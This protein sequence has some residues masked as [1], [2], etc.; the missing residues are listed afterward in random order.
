MPVK[1]IEQRKKTDILPNKNNGLRKDGW[2]NVLSGVGKKQDKTTHS[3]PGQILLLSDTLLSDMYDAPGL[4]SVVI[5]TLPND[6][7][8]AGWEYEND[9]EQKIENEMT[10]LDATVKINEAIKYTRVYRGAI[11]VLVTKQGKLEDPIKPTSGEITN[12][13]VYSAARLTT[14]TSSDIITDPNSKYFDD[15]EYF[16]VRLLNGDQIKVHRSRCLV[17]KGS[18]SSD[19]ERVDLQYLYWGLSI[20]QKIYDSLNYFETSFQSVVNVMQEFNIGKYTLKNLASLLAANDQASLEKIFTRIDIINV[21]KSVLNAVLLGEGEE[22][23]T[24]NSSLSG[25]PEVLDRMMMHLSSV[26]RIPVTK[27]FGRSAAGMNATGEGDTRD[28]YDDVHNTQE[29]W[30]RPRHQKLV[31]YIAGYVY[32][33]ST[34][35]YTITYNSLWE[36]TEKEKAETNKINADS[37]ALYIDRS[38]VTAEEVRKIRFSELEGEAPEPLEE[39]EEEK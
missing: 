10:R 20:F 37:D 26:A 31:N 6:M 13:K 1:E 27:L 19:Y 39:E 22:F 14:I 2:S 34:D 30:L 33:N 4:G 7:I 5:D 21:S 35:D 18:K 24:E 36:P 3:E 32:P 16:E 15:V 17:F 9:E 23:T 8:K 25:V 12:L 11:I 29:L 38:V 28:Y